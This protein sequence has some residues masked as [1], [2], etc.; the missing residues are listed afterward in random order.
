MGYFSD[1]EEDIT[2]NGSNFEGEN[3]CI[4][5]SQNF[6]VAIDVSTDN[7]SDELVEDEDNYLN[8]LTQC[9]DRRLLY[10]QTM[11]NKNK[12]YNSQLTGLFKD[13]KSLF[14]RCW[15]GSFEYNDLVLKIKE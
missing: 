9:N 2:T 8:K 10:T 12:N 15:S 7:C 1:S 6:S 13:L 3:A 11:I 4:P 14:S 5:A